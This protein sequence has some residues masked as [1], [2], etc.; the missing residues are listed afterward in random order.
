MADDT[1]LLAIPFAS[2]GM[3]RMISFVTVSQ[4][5]REFSV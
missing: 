5:V 4:K 3:L 2:G 1:T